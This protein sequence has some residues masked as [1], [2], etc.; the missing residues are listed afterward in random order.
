VNAPV[1]LPG[2][3]ACVYARSGNQLLLLSGRTEGFHGLDNRDTIF[4]SS[5][6]NPYI[7]VVNLTDFL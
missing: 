2:L 3:Q 1:G 4:R 5:R 7:Y 6:S